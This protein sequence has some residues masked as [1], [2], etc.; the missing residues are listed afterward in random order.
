VAELNTQWEDMRGGARLALTITELDEAVGILGK[1]A[2]VYV[3]R[4]VIAEAAETLEDLKIA[5]P[6]PEPH[7]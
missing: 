5:C 3:S 6:P 2:S 1:R 7:F 4:Q